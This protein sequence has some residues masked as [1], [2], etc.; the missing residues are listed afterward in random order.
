MVGNKILNINIR[1]A[2]TISKHKS[3]ISNIRSYPLNPATGHGFNPRINKGNP[4]LFYRM[5]MNDLF[6]R[7][8]K[9][10]GNIRFMEKI[11]GKIF[12]NIIPLIA[13][14]YDKVIESIMRIDFH[15]MP[16]DRMFADIYHWFRLKIG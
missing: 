8:S 12:L 4:P 14:A 7:I 13:E 9:I 11:M 10:K 1:N 2:V 5:L 15:Y 6:V 3:F 16:E